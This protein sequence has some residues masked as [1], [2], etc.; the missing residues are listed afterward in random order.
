[1][2]AP[3]QRWTSPEWASLES[4]ER[5]VAGPLPSPPEEANYYGVI[6]AVWGEFVAD[7]AKPRLGL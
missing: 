7:D 2:G 3:R 6:L 1:M 5:N 4:M